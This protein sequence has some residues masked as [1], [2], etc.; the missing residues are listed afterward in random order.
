MRGFDLAYSPGIQAIMWLKQR[1][2]ARVAEGY[3]VEF[4]AGYTGHDASVLT[5]AMANLDNY[6]TVS[7]AYIVTSHVSPCVSLTTARAGEIDY[8]CHPGHDAV[9]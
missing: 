2:Q 7:P 1:N 5:I 3:R 9:P 6:W 4:Q 8:R